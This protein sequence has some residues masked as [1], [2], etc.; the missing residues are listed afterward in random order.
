MS[1]YLSQA[2][3]S[4]MVI[5]ID[6]RLGGEFPTVNLH[7]CIKY[8]RCNWPQFSHLM[9]NGGMRGLENDHFFYRPIIRS[10]LTEKSGKNYQATDI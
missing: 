6:T 10:Y 2:F 5:T 3:F 7:T 9:Q 4:E 8:H 1:V